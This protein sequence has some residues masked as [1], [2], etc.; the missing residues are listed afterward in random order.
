MASISWVG[1]GAYALLTAIV[2][3][4]ARAGL[5][6]SQATSSRYTTIGILFVIATAI[7]ASKAFTVNVRNHGILLKWRKVV[8]AATFLLLPVLIFM[9]YVKGSKA[10]AVNH[11]ERIEMYNCLQNFEVSSDGCLKTIYPSPEVL[12]ERARYLAA[13]G[14]AGFGKSESW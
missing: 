4:I 8:V 2:T 12:R 6:T 14:W 13:L 9:T 7:L 3:G 5:G 11:Q 10:F 1:I